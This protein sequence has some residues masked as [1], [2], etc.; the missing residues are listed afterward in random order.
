VRTEV[1]QTQMLF[2]TRYAE[3]G[4]EDT[5]PREMWIE[6]RG[7]SNLALRD[8][9]GGCAN[10]AAALLPLIAV[11]NNAWIGDAEPKLAFDATPGLTEHPH[12]QSFVRE[13]VG[14]FP[15]IRR[16]VDPRATLRFME[17]VHTSDAQER[18]HR[19]AVHYAL[20]L[21]HWKA[22]HETL[23][24]AHL[25][26][27]MEALTPIVVERE[28]A[29]RGI[30]KDAL[31][32][33]LGITENRAAVRRI[34]LEAE[35]RRSILFQG[36]DEAATKAQ[37]AR[38]G[39]F[40][41]FLAFPKV[42]ELSADTRDRT[43][44]YLRAAIFDVGD[45][46]AET[47]A[48]LEQPPYDQPHRSWLARYIWG[49]VIGEVDEVAA[50]D[51]AYPMLR[52]TSHLKEW[53]KNPDGDTYSASPEESMTVVIG[54]NASYQRERFEIWGSRGVESSEAPPAD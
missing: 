41:G 32:S 36:D 8:V 4:H 6:I 20:A 14:T 44:R 13:E 24:Q 40:H 11:A 49:R 34:L 25:F 5:V 42:H 12:F 50:P 16:V 30:G 2:Q 19:A 9:I 35:L 26:I 43:A 37:R 23:A 3:E 28:A 53:T 46:D 38:N 45:V 31:A 7:G 54:P 39:F 10:A 51:Q 27:G 33:E 15:P 1:G 48:V 18:V 52:W 47:R 21:G 22:G 29:K 17:A